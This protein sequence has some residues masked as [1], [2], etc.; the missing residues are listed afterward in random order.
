MNNSI[1]FHISHPVYHK[2]CT[3]FHAL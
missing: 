3:V 2:L 1:V